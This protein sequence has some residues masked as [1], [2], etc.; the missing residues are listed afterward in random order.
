[1]WGSI[2]WNS[3]GHPQIYLEPACDQVFD[4]TILNP[5]KARVPNPTV[6]MKSRL[7]TPWILF[8]DFI[9][10]FFMFRSPPFCRENSQNV[11]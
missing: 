7:E 5:E 4:G 10:S 6:F 8:F 1:M 2:L 11:D 3:L 9:P